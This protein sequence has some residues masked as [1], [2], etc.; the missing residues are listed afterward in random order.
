[1]PLVTIKVQTP[2]GEY[3]FPT[4]RQHSLLRAF[5]MLLEHE[6]KRDFETGAVTLHERNDGTSE[7]IAHCT[8]PRDGTLKPDEQALLDQV[9]AMLR[10]SGYTILPSGDVARADGT[11][12]FGLAVDLRGIVRV[13]QQRGL[14]ILPGFIESVLDGAREIEAKGPAK[15]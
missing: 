10:D 15:P 14:G 7:L 2:L 13:V 12:V 9:N 6:L 3:P 5:Q 4:G 1:M 11:P 8:Q